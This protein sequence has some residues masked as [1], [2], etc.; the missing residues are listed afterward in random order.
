MSENPRLTS[1]NQVEPDFPTTST[2]V[3]PTMRP[4][5]ESP[6]ARSKRHIG[7]SLVYGR[8][9]EFIGGSV[10]QKAAI[11]VR[12]KPPY[13]I[14]GMSCHTKIK[15]AYDDI[16]VLDAFSQRIPPPLPNSRLH[17]MASLPYLAEA[18]PSEG[19]ETEDAV[20]EQYHFLSERPGVVRRVSF[21]IEDPMRWRRRDSIVHRHGECGHGSTKR[22]SET[23]QV[24]EHGGLKIDPRRTRKVLY[25]IDS[26]W[27]PSCT[28]RVERIPESSQLWECTSSLKPALE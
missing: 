7:P 18:R 11:V 25:A 4:A 23:S 16:R 27:C 5:K 22:S 19:H 10:L 12:S 6:K 1:Q 3:D 26:K 15:G 21:S 14:R 17:T 8:N 28:G 9:L 24:G 2:I 20:G 13:K